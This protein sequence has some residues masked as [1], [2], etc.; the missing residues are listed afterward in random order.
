MPTLEYRIKEH[1]I[2]N[3]SFSKWKKEVLIKLNNIKDEMNLL[4]L[5]GGSI[6]SDNPFYDVQGS[7]SDDGHVDVVY[8]DED[9]H[10]NVNFHNAV[11]MR[12]M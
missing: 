3:S 6:S 10:H 9:G 4:E 8:N 1:R 5:Y 11:R 12:E 7:D 2:G